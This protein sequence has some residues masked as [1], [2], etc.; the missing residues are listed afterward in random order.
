MPH[1]LDLFLNE[2]H[3]KREAF[4]RRLTGEGTTELDGLLK[5]AFLAEWQDLPATEKQD[6]RVIAV[7]SG[8]AIREYSSGTSMYICRASAITSWGTKTRHVVSNAHIISSPRERLI[9]LVSLRSEQAEHLVALKT[10]RSSDDV[11]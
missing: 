3:E 7:D 10:I 8:R 11:K 9:E 1:F 2:L 4:R 5:E 6:L